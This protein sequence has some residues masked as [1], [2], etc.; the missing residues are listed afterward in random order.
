MPD[1]V[2]IEVRVN[3][4]ARRFP[5]PHVPYSVAEIADQALECWREGAAIVHYHARDR[6]TG[7]ASLEG[8]EYAETVRRIKRASDL[9]TMPTNVPNYG[10]MKLTTRD[11][12][13]PIMEMAKDPATRPEL[14]PID[15]LS[16]NLDR[17]D[18]QTRTYLTG[19]LVYVN[20]TRDWQIFADSFKSVGIKPVPFLWNISSVRALGAFIAMGILEGPVW[21]ELALTESGLWAGHPGTMRGVQAFLDFFPASANWSW[22]VLCNGGNLLDIAADVMKAGGHIS[23]GLG[24]YHYQGLGL[25][26]NAELVTRTVAIARALGREVA[27]PSDVR[28]MLELG[29]AP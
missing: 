13:A 28:K 17:F 4:Y 22:S 7:G 2:I 29:E 5:N 9:I 3:E 25:P 23:I 11:R 21:C 12:I 18:D 26:T 1:K 14:S 20:T 6:L 24:D 10:A 8:R 16:C 15:L 27:S 19:D